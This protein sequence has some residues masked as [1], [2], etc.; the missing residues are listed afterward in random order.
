[1]ENFEEKLINVIQEKVI[2]DIAKQDL[3]KVEYSDRFQ[4]P[5]EFLNEIYRKGRLI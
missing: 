5:S 3:V 1:M 4:V 2:K